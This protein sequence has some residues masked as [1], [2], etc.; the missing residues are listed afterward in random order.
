[1]R[2]RHVQRIETMLAHRV[3]VFF[4]F[5]EVEAVF[6]RYETFTADDV[7]HDVD[8]SWYRF[9]PVEVAIALDGRAG[10]GRRVGFV[11]RVSARNGEQSG[12]HHQLQT[13]NLLQHEKLQNSNEIRL[14]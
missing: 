5:V 8:V 14:S 10:I 3:I 12:G 9:A 7:H 2:F 6:S 13:Y 11:S 1:I 4:H